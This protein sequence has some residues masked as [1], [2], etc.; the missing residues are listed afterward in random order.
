MTTSRSM[1][2]VPARALERPGD[3]LRG[4]AN[5]DNDCMCAGT[6]SDSYKHALSSPSNSQVVVFLDPA[7]I[8]AVAPHFIISA[9]DL[10][11]IAGDAPV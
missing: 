5:L 8:I 9:N 2:L 7:A 4:V 6:H 11:N 10:V 1:T 3:R